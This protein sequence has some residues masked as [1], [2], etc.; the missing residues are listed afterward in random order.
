MLQAKP[1]TV[2]IRPE[3]IE[4]EDAGAST[5][6]NGIVNIVENLGGE[7]YLHVEIAPGAP[8]LMVKLHGSHRPTRGEIT[9]HLPANRIYLFGADERAIPVLYKIAGQPASGSS[10]P[11]AG[12]QSLSLTEMASQPS[13]A[14]IVLMAPAVNLG[15]LPQTIMLKT[16]T[17]KATSLPVAIICPHGSS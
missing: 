15:R 9:L 8:L 14:G 10:S 3:H 7:T 16:I 6:L 11:S 17:G 12:A 4:L 2:G 1:I 13:A 5:A